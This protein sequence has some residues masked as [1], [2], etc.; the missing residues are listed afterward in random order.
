MPRITNSQQSSR[1]AVKSSDVANSLSASMRPMQG[2]AQSNSWTELGSA[3]G[4]ATPVI[5]TALEMDRDS[6]Y[7]AAAA[8][9][10]TGGTDAENRHWAYLKASKSL[11]TRSNFL[12]DVPMIDQ[13]VSEI[14]IDST[15]NPAEYNKQL[16]DIYSTFY[17]G[18]DK[19]QAE[20]LV[21][22]LAEHRAKT[23]NAY[24]AYHKEKVFQAQTGQLS[25]L[26]ETA[27]R[28]GTFDYNQFNTEVT[29]IFGQSQQAN[30]VYFATLLQKS[31]EL[32][33]PDILQNLPEKWA[34][35]KAT[36]KN[37]QAYETKI[38]TGIQQATAR[39]SA[40]SAAG[41]TEYTHGITRD[42]NEREASLRAHKQVM[43][44]AS[45]EGQVISITPGMSPEAAAFAVK[46]NDGANTPASESIATQQRHEK[47]L[48]RQG[49]FS[50][51]EQVQDYIN[52][53]GGLR[54][55]E[56]AAMMTN[57]DSYLDGQLYLN[58]GE[59]EA[60][61]NNTIGRQIKSLLEFPQ[62]LAALGGVSLIGEVQDTFN[63][64]V[65]ALT[66]EAIA[67]NPGQTIKPSKRREINE[68]A[69]KVAAELIKSHADLGSTGTETVPKNAI[70]AMKKQPQ[71]TTTDTTGIPPAALN[72]LQGFADDPQ[73]L[74]EFEEAF[75]LPAGSAINLISK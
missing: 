3:L 13:M 48:L 23:L 26:A 37:S 65:F 29:S 52:S 64:T 73:A 51:K 38:N 11:E 57:I 43:L 50:T 9:H 4:V 32:G 53:I 47:I 68:A 21:P 49:Q 20:F 42:K 46:I 62:R 58:S 22:A 56:R 34:G 71:P 1:T 28:S 36:F 55:T 33:R 5:G 10:A 74:A 12:Q 16:D 18:M 45:L 31:V 15:V 8:D 40:L 24:G 39:A 61:Y 30:E 70:E 63:D 27:L 69:K 54:G 44:D 67:E 59:S 60:F 17:N 72:E 41:W 19:E 2:S 6:E 35:G 25:N 75:N 66:A 7:A 14:D